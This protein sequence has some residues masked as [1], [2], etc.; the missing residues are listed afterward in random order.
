MNY[1]SNRIWKEKGIEE[2]G[3]SVQQYYLQPFDVNTG[4]MSFG[5]YK[6]YLY[7]SPSIPYTYLNWILRKW[8][9]LNG[10]HRKMIT[11][12]LKEQSTYY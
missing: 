11:Q 3:K 9:K 2:K 5:K 4:R 8:D 6:G 12:H 7:T 1:S 10:Y